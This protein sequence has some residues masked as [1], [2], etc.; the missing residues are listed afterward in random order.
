MILDD[1]DSVYRKPLHDEIIGLVAAGTEAPLLDKP[2]GIFV[3]RLDQIPTED[4]VLLQAVAR[5]VL[6]EDTTS[7]AE[8]LDRKP[9]K[10]A[11][12]ASPLAGFPPGRRRASRAPRRPAARDLIFPNG[13]G[14]FTQ[15]GREYVITLAAGQAT[16]APW[17]NVLANAGFG[18]IVSEAG[19][20]YTWAQNCHEYRLTPWHNDPVVDP[21]GE[22]FYLRDEETGQFWSPTPL[23]A[24]G[25]TPYVIRHGFGYSIFEHAE[26]GIAS[27][28]CVYV[29]TDAPVKF[30]VCKVRNLSPRP[31]RLSV[32]GYWEWVLGD[33]RPKTLLHV[34]TEL[35]PS[36]ALLARNRYHA[37]F[38]ERIAFVDA[39]AIRRS[40]TGDRLE[41]VGRGGSLARPA[42]LGRARLSG[43]VGAGLD[44]ACAMQVPLDLAPGQEAEVVFRIGAGL[45]L[46]EVQGLIQRFRPPGA[47]R[48]ALEQTP[49]NTGAARS[50]P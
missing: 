40:V 31:R 14:G 9:A 10:P 42:A 45:G 46:A 28:L 4:R 21:S 30:A 1:D 34:Q 15:D 2:G 44:P 6:G 33:L 47:P 27:E 25:A 24:R 7:L 32:T 23:P 18:T 3:R 20:S 17:I 39:G 11:L 37:D 48:A 36:G 41:F 29:A 12:P 19:S 50:A 16:P 22:A 43:R 49:G 35:D 8:Q 5:I 13:L 26:H 38:A